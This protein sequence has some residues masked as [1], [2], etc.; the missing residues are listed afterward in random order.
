MI[1]RPVVCKLARGDGKHAHWEKWWLLL[2]ICWT[3]TGSRLA[4]KIDDKAIEWRTIVVNS[5]WHSFPNCGT[6]TRNRSAGRSKNAKVYSH[7]FSDAAAISDANRSCDHC[8]SH[9]AII[10]AAAN[11]TSSNARRL[12]CLVFGVR[13]VG[14]FSAG[15]GKVESGCQCGQH[16]HLTRTNCCFDNDFILR[17]QF[18]QLLVEI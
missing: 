15:W 4:S 3:K 7:E 2:F 9:S 18:V 5:A 6:G 17:F 16:R 8:V 11:E 14:V 12:D 10:G 1:F 13:W